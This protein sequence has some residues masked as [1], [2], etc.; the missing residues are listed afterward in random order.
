M[1][2]AAEWPRGDVAMKQAGQHAVVIGASMGGLLAARV[3]ADSH[4]Q[5]TVVERDAFPPPGEPRK[6]V[7]QGR[8]AHGLLAKG[9]E[10]L[11]E[12]FPGL[13]Q[14]LLDQ[15]ALRGDVTWDV[16]WGLDGGMHRRVRSGMEGLLVS[17]PLLEAQVRA[18]L[19][20]LPNVRALEGVHVSGL[21]TSA[22]RAHVTGVRMR[23]QGS[24]DGEETLTADLVVDAGGRGSRTPGWLEA[25]GYQP[26]EEEQ[27]K[28]G[29]GY[30][31]RFYRRSPEDFGGAL[32]FFAAPA[33]DAPYK[34]GGVALAQEGDRW[35]VTL[36]GYLGDHA[37]PDEEGFLAYAKSFW[38][39]AI[40]DVI[41]K[42]EPLGEIATYKY[43]ANQRRHY[44]RLGRFPGGLLVF[45]DAICSFNPIYGQGMTVAALETVAL[46][47]CLAEG[48][49][50]LPQR[51]FQRASKMV[52]VPWSIAVG[53]DLR[54]REVEGPRPPM[55][56]FIN[57]YVGKLQVAARHD[58][59][60]VLAFQKVN[61][62]M[63]PPPSILAP[64]IAARVLRE[65]LRRPRRTSAAGPGRTPASRRIPDA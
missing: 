54:V 21:V 22:D 5:V 47:E 7:P 42:A 65:N 20:A 10:I 19:L 62:L 41:K 27:V 46:R 1:M 39:P 31:S 57:W 8:H 49:A 15:G 9:R 25:L 24:D 28:I 59:A 13:T 45:G 61:N 44:E 38:T 14:E 43:Q 18:R 16:R 51:F 48:I 53:G 12:L 6:G 33:P 52:D 11:E 64:Q 56:R 30:A 60:V 37:T 23:R 34:R 63:A 2:K 17:R 50:G 32:G 36:A 29:I 35:L 55:V 3:L 58:P 40:Y 26:P 4:A